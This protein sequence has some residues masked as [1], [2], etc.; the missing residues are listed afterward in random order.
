[1]SSR[2]SSKTLPR[3]A[4][5]RDPRDGRFACVLAMILLALVAAAG[6]FLP[7]MRE[8]LAGLV[9]ASTERHIAVLPF[10][11]VGDPQFEPVA[12]GLMDALTNE[13][14][15][16][17]AAQKSLWVVPAS[18]VRSHKVRDPGAAYRDLGATMVVQGSVQRKGPGVYLTVVLIDSKRLRQIGS[19]QVQDSS[20]DLASV[21]NQA[22]SH[23][24]RMMRVTMSE[25]A[26]IPEK[27][28]A[29]SSYESYLKA[30]GYIQRYD[31]PGNLR[32]GNRSPELRGAKRTR[33]SR[34]VMPPWERRYRLEISD[35]PPPGLARASRC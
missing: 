21:Q 4:G 27:S 1:M 28:T 10:E 12:S 33:V 7:A 16:L 9:Y 14:S 17:E 34:W 35:R 25:T 15:N 20:G 31:K 19:V 29:P 6:V 30:L 26:L 23:L 8:R 24:A 13:L 2:S 11:N 3:R 22:V 18:E 5:M 32:L